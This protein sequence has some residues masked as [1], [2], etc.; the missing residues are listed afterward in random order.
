M[1]VPRLSEQLSDAGWAKRLR[2][3]RDRADRYQTPEQRAVTATVISRALASGASAFALTGSTARKRRTAI[4]DLDYHV[5]GSRLDVSDLP[6]DVDVVTTSP[7]RF[8]RSLLDG[9]DFAQW[10]LRC[11]C[12]L[13]DT[14]P[15][16]EGVRLIVEM[17]LWPDAQRKLK[18]LDMHRGEVE[19]LIQMGDRDAAQEQLR[20]MLTTAARGLLLQ[21][22]VFPL[23]RKELPLQLERAGYGPFAQVLHGLIHTT[24]Q[25]DELRAGLH[26]LDATLETLSTPLSA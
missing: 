23:A 13:L 21:T 12:V 10:T 22:G 3:D 17:D 4:S 15:M 8:R 14:G 2:A 6:G 1:S 5:I 7:E 18:S 11:G 20:A 26:V 19:R 25:L 24:P 9:D 16:R